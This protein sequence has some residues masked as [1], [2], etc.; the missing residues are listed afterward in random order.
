MDI[1]RLQNRIA[2][3]FQKASQACGA[4]TLQYR[5]ISSQSPLDNDPVGDFFCIFDDTPN[6]AFKT[7]APWGHAFRYAAPDNSGIIPG[8]YLVTNSTPTAQNYLQDTYFV[9][10]C[11]SARAILVTLTNATISLW[12]CDS[13]TNEKT[14]GLTVPQGPVFRADTMIAE[15]WPVSLLAKHSGKP[16]AARLPTDLPAQA[17]SLLMPNIPTI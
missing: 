4:P 14:V 10:R 13:P 7:P 1:F 12:C 8:D 2:L 16:P 15:N 5:S 6:F 17:Y 9:C 3:G 11:E